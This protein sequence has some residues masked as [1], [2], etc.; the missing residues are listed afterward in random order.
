MNRRGTALILGA[1]S[2]I[3]AAVA[4][5]LADKGFAVHVMARRSSELEQTARNIGGTWSIADATDPAGLEA[6]IAAQA[7]P[8]IAVYAAGV[9]DEGLIDK[10]SVD[11]W[12]RTIEVNLSGAFYFARAVTRR[13]SEGSRIVFLSSVSAA[14]GQPRLSAYAASKAGLN[15]FAESLGAELEPRGISV[16]V[17]SPGPVATELLNRPG[18]SPFQLEASQVGDVVGWL[19]D[20][21]EDVV[22]RDIVLRAVTQGPYSKRRHPAEMK[23]GI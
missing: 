20:L 4:R 19:T 14:K 22:L 15:R 2:G 8:T 21:P 18:T 11:L 7:P 13:M 9:L 6:E 1:S 12:Q 3:G 17:V 10:M 5:S 16:H 23:N